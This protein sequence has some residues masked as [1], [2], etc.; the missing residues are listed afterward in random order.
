MHAKISLVYCSAEMAK[1]R[2]RFKSLNHVLCSGWF[3]RDFEDL[4]PRPK[5][6][7]VCL[8]IRRKFKKKKLVRMEKNVE[9]QHYLGLNLPLHAMSL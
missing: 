6:R 2:R 8:H 7:S 3:S 4:E 1:I 5:S 9:F